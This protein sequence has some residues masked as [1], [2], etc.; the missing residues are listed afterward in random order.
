LAFLL[1]GNGGQLYAFL[2]QITG[3]YTTNSESEL[4]VN[5]GAANKSFV[6]S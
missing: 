2:G 4:R 1:S 6:M 3:D 5:E